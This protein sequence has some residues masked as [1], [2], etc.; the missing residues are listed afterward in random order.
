MLPLPPNRSNLVTFCFQK[1]KR[2]KTMIDTNDKKITQLSQEINKLNQIINEADA[3][4]S[5]QKRDYENVMNERDIL[6]YGAPRCNCVLPVY[7]CACVAVEV[8]LCV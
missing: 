4:K 3:E 5:K 2:H 6:G 8:H 1:I 7:F